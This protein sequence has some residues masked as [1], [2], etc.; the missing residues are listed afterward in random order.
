VHEARKDLKKL[1]ALLRL[2]RGELGER[3]FAL[4]NACFR[5]A[6]RELA[7]VRDG[8]VML[9]TL[10][11]LDIEAGLGWELR[12]A[13]RA[14]NAR[15]GGGSRSSAAARVVTMLREA[16][17]RVDDWP[18]ERDSFGALE[19]G[20]ERTYR[21]GRRDFRAVRA[22]TSVEGLHEWRKRVKERCYEHTLLRPIWPPVMQAFGDEA[23]ELADRLGDDHDLAM[24]ADCLREHTDV[25]PEFFDAVERRRSEL[26]ADALSLGARLYAERPAGYTRRLR[27]LWE[28]SGAFIRAP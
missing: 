22:S 28:A 10:T 15:N 23:H 27:R 14:H 3:A 11:A 17:G 4:E 7:A 6:G 18:L 25:G 5:D 20:L 12:K 8:D 19:E 26:Q 21:R 2:A 13:I 24:L 1:R 9:E 16:R